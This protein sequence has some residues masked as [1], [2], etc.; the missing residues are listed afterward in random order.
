M[1]S[2]IALLSNNYNKYDVNDN[3]VDKCCG[4]TTINSASIHTTLMQDI[5]NII[6]CTTTTSRRDVK[7]VTSSTTTT[8]YDSE[9]TTTTCVGEFVLPLQCKDDK[10]KVCENGPWRLVKGQNGGKDGWQRFPLEKDDPKIKAEHAKRD[11]K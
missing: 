5:M 4:R 10:G 1:A 8:Q 11:C 2:I 3:Q 9:T 6:G 7:H